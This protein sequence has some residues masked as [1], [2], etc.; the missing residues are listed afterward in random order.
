[1]LALW[2]HPAVLKSSGEDVKN[3]KKVQ[4]WLLLTL[5][6]VYHFTG[7]GLIGCFLYLE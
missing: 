5:V 2:I 1:M 3:I 7:S 6:T 4:F